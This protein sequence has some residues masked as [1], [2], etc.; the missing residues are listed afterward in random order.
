MKPLVMIPTYNEVESIGPLV[1]E[2]LE[3]S[4]DLEILV[5]DDN[6]PDGTP[7]SMSLKER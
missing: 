1:R 7:E 6:S 5:I 3:R 2:L 4:P